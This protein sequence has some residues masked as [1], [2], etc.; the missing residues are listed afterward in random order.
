M[1]IADAFVPE[2]RSL[3]VNA[4]AGGPT[5]G[6]AVNSGALYRLPTFSVFPFILSGVALGIAQ[7][8]IADFADSMRA[9]A[10]TYTGKRVS[11]LA[12]LQLRLAEAAALAD[13]AETLML[14]D[15]DEAMRLT[16]AGGDIPPETRARWR[17]DGAYTTQMCVRAVDLL[18][19]GAGGNAIYLTPPLQRAWR[20]VHAAAAHVVV[21]WD[22]AGTLYG[23]VALG[24]AADVPAL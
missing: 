7:G 22:A 3:P 4:I 11:E 24:L 13:A 23:R 2:H 20:D 21:N 8:A 5:P 15:C 12:T 18:F 14:A 10:A 9:R 6:S 1:A 19:A 16:E 17:R